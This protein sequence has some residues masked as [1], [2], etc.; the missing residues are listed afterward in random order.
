MHAA[1]VALSWKGNEGL[2]N[3]GFIIPSQMF[4]FP[5]P[6]YALLLL[7]PPLWYTNGQVVVDTLE[8]KSGVSF[9]CRLTATVQCG[10]R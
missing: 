10:S 6:V 8:G 2:W 1:T 9:P 3:L 7:P 4:F 5:S